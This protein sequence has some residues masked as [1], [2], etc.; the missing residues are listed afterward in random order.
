MVPPIDVS[1]IT[2]KETAQKAMQTWE[3][4]REQARYIAQAFAEFKE[5]NVLLES[6][7]YKIDKDHKEG[8]KKAEREEFL[9]KTDREKTKMMV[10]KKQFGNNQNAFVIEYTDDG[11]TPEKFIGKQKFTRDAI[12]ELDQ[13][14]YNIKRRLPEH[15]WKS[16][17]QN[18]LVKNFEKDLVKEWEE[19]IKYRL[20]DGTYLD[21]DEKYVFFWTNKDPKMANFIRLIQD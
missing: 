11:K 5:W 4:S 2:S 12:E 18:S 1:D 20:S 17:Y 9:H 3:I 7:D 8:W 15:K 19:T 16:L 13:K 21:V 6:A 14:Y 10:L